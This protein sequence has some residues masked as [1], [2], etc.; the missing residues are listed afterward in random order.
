MNYTA[1]Q[2]KDTFNMMVTGL[3]MG[4]FKLDRITCKNIC[5]FAYN[6][7]HLTKGDTSVKLIL[8]G[9]NKQIDGFGYGV[10][11]VTITAERYVNEKCV[12]ISD[13]LTVYEI[14]DDY[15]TDDLMTIARVRN[16]SRDRFIRRTNK[17]WTTHLK[18]SKIPVRSMLY[19]I[20]Q[21]NDSMDSRDRSYNYVIRDVYFSHTDNSRELVVVIKHDDCNA[22][23]AMYLNV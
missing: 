7:R 11:T 8:K 15:Y 23:E 3:E 2:V 14:G 5:L 21:I 9:G 13:I 12:D 18:I 17:A 1:K 19:L 22:T 10:I 4:G 6:Y 16:L 20:N